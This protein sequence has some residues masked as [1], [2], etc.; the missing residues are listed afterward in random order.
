[1]FLAM[2]KKEFLLLF[3]DK[4]ALFALFIMPSIFIIIMSVAMRDQF[5]HDNISF[6]IAIEDADN[7]KISKTLV[8]TLK[9]DK[10]F[11]I[12]NNKKN[13]EFAL[14][15]PK[16]YYTDPSKKIKIT[17]KG[18]LKS[19][20]IEM[21]KA[22]L[23]KAILNLQLVNISKNIKEFS[24]ETSLSIDALTQNSSDMY[25]VSYDKDMDIPN[26]TQQSVPSWIVFGMFFVIIPMSTIYINEKKQNTL[27]RLSSMNISILSM[28]ISKSIPYLL[29]NQIQV[30]IMIAVGVFIVPLFNTPAL[31]INGSVFALFL[32][33]ISLS[34]SAIGLSNLIAVGATSSEQATTIGGISNILLGAIGGVMVPK[35]IMPESMQTLAQFSPMSWGIDGFLTIF[36]KAGNVSMVLK[37]SLMLIFFGI[38]CLSISML[39]LNRK[40]NKGL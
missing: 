28:T 2:V 40:I 31:E 14:I 16:D 22:K 15:I 23:T 20:S 13:I 17:V 37:D 8:K 33:S 32:V 3:R 39:I 25:I 19:D 34:I 5:S 29:V 1:M 7:T 38:I 30:W 12:L 26:S 6:S 9:E 35:F 24:P 21:F 27:T 36:L 11:K 4:Q 18:T 10:N